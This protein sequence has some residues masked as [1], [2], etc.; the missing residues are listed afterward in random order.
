MKESSYFFNF[1]EPRQLLLLERIE[2][3]APDSN[4]KIEGSP[5]NPLDWTSK[6]HGHIWKAFYYQNLFFIINEI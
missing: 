4:K 5:S 1:S 3:Y 2:L 6:W